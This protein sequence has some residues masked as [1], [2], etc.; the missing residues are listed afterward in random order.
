[1]SPSILPR[2]TR[3]IQQLASRCLLTRRSPLSPGP[4]S[5]LVSQKARLSTNGVSKSTKASSGKLD[6]KSPPSENPSYPAFSFEG[7]G[8]NRTVKYVVIGA[9]SVLAT[10]ESVFWAK[11]L[12]ARFSPSS[13]DEN[14]T[15]LN[16]LFPRW[17]L[18]SRSTLLSIRS[19]Q[20]RLRSLFTQAS[21]KL[22]N[23]AD[24]GP[25]TDGHE[26]EGGAEES[27]P[28]IETGCHGKSQ[29]KQAARSDLILPY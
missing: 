1:M 7:L 11:T 5:L 15:T 13:E 29:L 4:Q 24:K 6:P 12:S 27:R 26:D 20:R 9:L 21:V 10:M 14:A 23:K 16:S 25:Q 28:V 18:H 3:P 8:A 2:A 19:M 17:E 22:N